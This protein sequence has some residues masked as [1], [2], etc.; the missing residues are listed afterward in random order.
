MDILSI[1]IIGSTSHSHGVLLGGRLQLQRR[2]HLLVLN[3]LL[4]QSIPRQSKCRDQNQHIHPNGVERRWHRNDLVY[5]LIPPSSFLSLR[6]AS[7][8]VVVVVAVVIAVI[9]IVPKHILRQQPFRRH[10]GIG[11]A[12]AIDAGAGIGPAAAFDVVGK[13][14]KVV[15]VVVVIVIV[16]GIVKFVELSPRGFEVGF[17]RHGE[18][19]GENFSSRAAVVVVVVVIVGWHD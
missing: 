13:F 4:R 14:F 17:G 2:L 6:I 18:G 11:P 5:P 15:V 3:L 10:G 1:G 16:V 9:P 12:A 7:L 19:V 8:P